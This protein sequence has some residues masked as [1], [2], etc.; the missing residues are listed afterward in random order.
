MNGQ[1]WDSACA[2][3]ACAWILC[4]GILSWADWSK[5]GAYLAVAVMNDRRSFNCGVLTKIGP[6]I[7]L[8]ASVSYIL[9][10]LLCELTP[11]PTY[12]E[13]STWKTIIR[14]SLLILTANVWF[15]GSHWAMHHFPLLRSAHSQHHSF[16]QPYAPTS[17]YCHPVEMLLVNWP[18]LFVCPS[19]LGVGSSSLNAWAVGLALYVCIAHCGHQV[20]PRWLVDVGYHEKH[21]RSEAL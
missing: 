9:G 6:N 1:E 19:T 13:E 7:F 14:L 5:N 20:V 11:L 21:H 2:S 12:S 3:F 16:R 15:V 4:S 8:N 17:I 10:K 18:L